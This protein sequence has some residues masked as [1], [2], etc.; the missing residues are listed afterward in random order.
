MATTKILDSGL[1]LIGTNV[2][3]TINFPGLTGI[4]ASQITTNNLDI[5]NLFVVPTATTV[6]DDTP[7][8]N[9]ISGTI[10]TAVTA[11]VP[12]AVKTITLTNN[13][14]LASSKVFCQVGD[15]GGT[16]VP[17]IYQVTPGAGSCV[18]LVLNN[19]ETGG[20]NLSAAFD[21]DFFVVN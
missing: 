5:T 10:T 6:G 11:T 2:D 3:G 13:K 15:Y 16:G 14:I 7:E 1:N 20:S 12:R 19:A 8:I 9:A 21:I 4:T 17:I 18:I